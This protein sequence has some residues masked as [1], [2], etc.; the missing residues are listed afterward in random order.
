[1]TT[2]DQHISAIV[3]DAVKSALPN[4]QLI[5]P[6]KTCWTVKECAEYLRQSEGH[7]RHLA[8]TKQIPHFYSGDNLRFH[9]HEVREWRG[10]GGEKAMS[11]AERVVDRECG[12]RKFRRSV[13]V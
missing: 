1:M 5:Q 9:P 11:E 13:K 3:I 6:D 10:T 4:I 12:V 7:V 2:L 8:A